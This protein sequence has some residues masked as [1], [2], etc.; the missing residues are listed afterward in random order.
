[1]T[2][3]IR[4]EG[5]ECR[6]VFRGQLDE[7]SDFRLLL[8]QVPKKVTLDLEGI[9]RINSSGVRQW[10]DFVDELRL[11]G[12]DF[13]LD[14]CSLAVVAQLNMVVNFGGKAPVLSLFAPYHCE[15]CDEERLRW[16]K[17][18]SGIAMEL[19][20][21]FPCPVCSTPMELDDLPARFLAFLG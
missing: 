14:R 21:T 1:V 11:A 20:Q 10:I 17:V 12:V 19:S 4:T 16:L 5:D 2:W 18:H 9:E 6:L 15:S 3:E 7:H 13:V 8:P